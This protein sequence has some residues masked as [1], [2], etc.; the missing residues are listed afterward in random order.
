[1]MSSISNTRKAH[2]REQR[3]VVAKMLLGQMSDEDFLE[4]V[5]S[6]D[7]CLRRLAARCEKLGKN[8]ELLKAKELGLKVVL[9]ARGRGRPPKE[10]PYAPCL[11][12]VG[13][14]K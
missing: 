14:Q 6:M 9:D 11:R 10:K 4:V 12:L 3:I 2:T 1:M 5:D 7:V 13:N 8:I